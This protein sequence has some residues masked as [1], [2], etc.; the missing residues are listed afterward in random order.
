MIE[1]ELYVQITRPM[2]ECER[3]AFEARRDRIDRCSCCGGYF[4]IRD[5]GRV[6]FVE[7]GRIIKWGPWA[8]DSCSQNGLKPQPV[9]EDPVV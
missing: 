6:G 7:G 3:I 8:C 1:T 5:L 2:T 9:W 4:K